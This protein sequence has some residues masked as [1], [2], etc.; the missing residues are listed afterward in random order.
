[1]RVEAAA[2][3]D[4]AEAAEAKAAE[5]ALN[6]QAPTDAQVDAGI[7]RADI[8]AIAAEVVASNPTVAASAASMAQSATGLIPKWKASTAYA[9]GQMVVAPSGDLVTAKVSF[10]SAAAYSDTNWNLSV[11]ASMVASSLRNRGVLANGT[12]I[13]TLR[14]TGVYHIASSTSAATMLNLPFN[15]PGQV[16]VTKDPGSTL[17]TQKGIGIPL[18]G[19]NISLWSRTTRSAS[20]WDSAWESDRQVKGPLPE[21][22]NLGT[23][24]TPGTWIISNATS[25]AT[26]TGLPQ[27]NGVTLADAAVLEIATFPGQSAGQERIEIYVADGNYARFSRIARTASG[28]W[29]TWQHDN[30]APTAPPATVASDA[31][32][33]NSVLISNFTQKMG[34][35]RRVTTAT[36]AFRFDHGLANFNAYV[37]AI[38]EAYGWKYSLALCSGQ[39][40]RSE[41]VG[42]TQAMVNAWVAAGLAEIWNHTKDHGSGDNSEAAW[43]AAIK[44]G[45]TELES[46]LPAAAGK[47]FGLAPPGSTGTNFGDFIFGQTLPEFTD[48]DG[49]RFILQ[50]HAVVAGY[51]TTEKRVQD[52]MV[53]QGMGHATIDNKNLAYVQGYVEQAKATKTAMQF[54]LHPSRINTAGYMDTATLTSI[55]E[56][57]RA[58]ELAG[59][60]KIVSPYE[61]LLCDVV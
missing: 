35:R 26:M 36:I 54:M 29:P 17:V 9:A 38:F 44:D 58:E 55:T 43:K 8:P 18:T 11:A 19:G 33:A 3:K 31:G 50:N 24:R 22:T 45:L 21:G 48:T 52:G 59:R 7:I 61:Q 13:N 16:L 15:V 23:F 28:S 47:I 34:G 25:A 37:R 51:L 42:V 39:W 46:Q 2:S 20:T 56:Y 14:E 6:A 40:D 53:R 27:L 30:P 32:L 4:A 12:D 10:T 1:M 41:N 5:A 60:I 57:I 49:I